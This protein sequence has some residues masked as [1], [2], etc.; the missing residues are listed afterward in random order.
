[1][2]GV[3][4]EP[5]HTRSHRAGR[6]RVRADGTV[7]LQSAS[8]AGQAAREGH[9]PP[10]VVADKQGQGPRG[11]PSRL[12]SS[13]C[14]RRRSPTV[15]LT[16]RKAGSFELQVQDLLL[17]VSAPEE[18]SEEV[19]AA[20]LSAWEQLHAYSLRHPEFRTSKTPVEV[21]DTAPAIV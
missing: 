2:R 6:I 8:R 12:V 20:A 5:R 1:R 10:R 15:P 4:P 18:Y 7:R 9:G 3:P 16:K 21:P 14:P 11:G 13:A 17:R 19:R